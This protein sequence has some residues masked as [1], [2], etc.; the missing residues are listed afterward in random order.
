MIIVSKFDN[1]H[2]CQLATIMF[3]MILQV[4]KHAGWKREGCQIL[5]VI[6]K[7]TKRKKEEEEDVRKRRNNI[8]EE[9]YKEQSE[10]GRNLTV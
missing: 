10:R 1:F 6:E 3:K 2:T 4:Q 5:R 8:E 9:E 7:K